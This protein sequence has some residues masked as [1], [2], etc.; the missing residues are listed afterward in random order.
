M[1]KSTEQGSHMV[2]FIRAAVNVFKEMLDL[3][4]SK[5]TPAN[6]G[7]FFDSQGFTV[8]VGLTDGWR[9]RFILDMSQETAIKLATRLTGEDY[10]SVADEEVLLA[11]AEIGNI[12]S[13]NAITDINNSKHGLNIRLAPPS[14]FAGQGMSMFNLRLSSWSVFME[15]EVGTIK[16]NVAVEEGKL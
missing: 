2:A 11:G 3:A 16:I 7:D 10:A 9:G 12:I 4:I 8:I 15:T 5:G 14:V 13:G 1:D 6:E